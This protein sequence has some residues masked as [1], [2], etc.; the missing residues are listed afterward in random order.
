MRTVHSGIA[1]GVITPPEFG[2]ASA[3]LARR[4]ARQPHH[5]PD[6][7]RL[8]VE[9]WCRAP[10]GQPAVRQVPEDLP[11]DTLGGDLNGHEHFGA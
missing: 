6:F 5:E 8:L 4:Q 9:N 10:D 3:S 1:A 7:A 11:G 2:A